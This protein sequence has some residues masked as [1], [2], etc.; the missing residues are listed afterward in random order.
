MLTG[1]TLE[2][3]ELVA[4]LADAQEEGQ[5]QHAEEEPWGDQDADDDTAANGT[6]HEASGKGQDVDDDQMLEPV[7]V[8]EAL[9]DDIDHQ[10]AQKGQARIEEKGQGHHGGNQQACRDHANHGVEAP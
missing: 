9:Y 1:P 8:E 7:G 6:E 5:E 3:G 2:Q 4:A 10:G